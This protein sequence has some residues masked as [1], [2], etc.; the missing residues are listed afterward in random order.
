VDLEEREHAGGHGPEA[1]RVVDAEKQAAHDREEVN[2]QE[3]QHHNVPGV[4]HG[5]QAN[6]K[7]RARMGAK[8]ATRQ[9]QK[10]VLIREPL[11]AAAATTAAGGHVLRAS[12]GRAIARNLSAR[13]GKGGCS[14]VF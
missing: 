7:I 1:R 9:V 6:E 10:N 4:Q 8:S 3:E 12:F 13:H 5:W 14:W 2:H 11:A